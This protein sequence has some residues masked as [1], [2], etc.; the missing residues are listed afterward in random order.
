MIK[1]FAILFLLGMFF[2]CKLALPASAADYIQPSWPDLLRTLVRTKALDLNDTRLIDQYGLVTECELY[3]ALHNDDFKW[4]QV[5][6]TIRES[7]RMNIDS[8]PVTYG[9]EVPIDLDHYDF[10][11][12]LYVFTDMTAI[13]AINAFLLFEYHNP[14]CNNQ[15]TT[16]LPRMYRAVLDAPFSLEGMPITQKDGEAMLQRM[17]AE[18]NDHHRIY[19]RFNLTITFVAP[20]QRR[21]ETNDLKSST[22]YE[23][24]GHNDVRAI[25]MQARLDSI[26]FFEDQQMTRL[27]HEI[28]S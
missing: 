21:A 15:D 20:W 17:R 25:H 3:M 12:K 8:F 22:V 24:A 23:Q 10:D 16:F 26:D 13:K 18:G 2:L 28:K 6:N 27:I 19:A 11:Q 5:R 9:Y 14:P 1:R 4:N 7:V